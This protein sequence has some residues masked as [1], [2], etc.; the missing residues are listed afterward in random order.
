MKTCFFVFIGTLYTSEY[1]VP[2]IYFAEHSSK[3]NQ[4]V[5]GIGGGSGCPVHKDRSCYSC[6]RSV[7]APLILCHTPQV[8]VVFMFS[9]RQFFPHSIQFPCFFSIQYASFVFVCWINKERIRKE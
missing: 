2:G 3:S 1:Y 6:Y 5:Y 4:Y 9:S 7:T 8:I